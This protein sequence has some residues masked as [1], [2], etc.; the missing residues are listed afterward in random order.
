MRRFTRRNDVLWRVDFPHMRRFFQIIAAAFASIAEIT[1]AGPQPVATFTI[2]EQFGVSHPLQIIDFDFPGPADPRR[3]YMIGPEGA[4][5]AFQPLAG[6]KIAVQTDLPANTKRSWHLFAG[7]PP[8]AM[9]AEVRVTTGPQWIEIANGVT[10]VR[11][12]RVDNAHSSLAPIQGVRLLNGSWSATGPNYLSLPVNSPRPA[13]LEA[14]TAE[15][16]VLESGPLRARIQVEY[17]YDRPPLIYSTRVLVPGGPGYYRSI[18][19]LD[20]GSPSIRIEDETDMDL[21][22]TLNFYKEVQPNQGRYR[23][24]HAT[25]V[26]FGQEPDGSLYHAHENGPTPDAQRDF[27]YQVPT[28]SSYV[29]GN[30]AGFSLLQRLGLWNPW[31]FDSGWY[32]MMYN[33]SAPPEAP[34]IGIFPGP[35]SRLIGSGNSGPGLMFLP[36]EPEANRVAAI[37]FQSNRRSPDAHVTPHIRVPWAIFVGSKEK[38][39]G[40]PGA[41]Q[42]I[43]KQTDLYAGI[44]LNKVYRY[45]LTYPDP[46][47]GVQPLYMRRD[48]FMKIVNRVRSEPAYYQYLY[49]AEPSARPM[50]DLWRD[51]KGEKADHQIARIL[52][53]ARSWLDSEVNGEGMHDR[54]YSY[55]HGGLQADM[56]APVANEL[57]TVEPISADVRER[58]K[59]ALALFC[60]LLWDDDLVPMTGRADVNLGTPNMPV[61]QAQY[62]NLYAI[63]LARNPAMKEHAAAVAGI[64]AKSLETEINSSGAQRASPH[65]A[66]ASMEPLLDTAQQL[67]LAGMANLFQSEPV[68]SKF[69]RFYMSMLTPPEVRFGTSRKLIS[70]GDG[71]TESSPIFGELG[72]YLAPVDPALSAEL[73]AA[74]K[75]SGS[76]HSGFHGTTVVKIDGDLP[77]SHLKLS[78][79]Q[80]PGWCSVLRSGFNTPNESALWF[81][82]GDFYSD[83]RHYD[84]GSVTFYA[85]GAP[86]AIDW[87]SIYT[88]ATSAPY[89]HSGV[90]PEEAIGNRWDADSPKLDASRVPWVRSVQEGFADFE[91]ATYSVASFDAANGS[92]W[93]RTVEMIHPD[94]RQPLILINDLVDGAYGATPRVATLNMMARDQVTTPAG[95]ITPPLRLYDLARKR[96]DLPSATPPVSLAAGLNRFHFQGQF[97]VDWDLYTLSSQPQQFLIGSWGHSSHPSTEAGEFQRVNG[98]PFHEQQYIFRVRGTGPLTTLIVPSRPGTAPPTITRNGDRIEYRSGANT[99]GIIGSDFQAYRTRSRVTLTA[100]GSASATAYGVSISG[101]PAEATLKYDHAFLTITGPKGRREFQLGGDWESKGPAVQVR[102]G[103]VAVDFDGGE[104]LNLILARKQAN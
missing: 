18:I 33:R 76:T 32:W 1:A 65:Y 64:V 58:L 47:E 74:W 10:G 25:S 2:S 56:A 45:Q 67:R 63:L 48:Q 24:H 26:A 86:I 103:V 54:L 27:G 13:R 87:G 83:H 28:W 96:L 82:N 91:G 62:R 98:Q 42:N 6:G 22:Y 102:P 69:A 99:E 41:T 30:Y 93:R 78:S 31:I 85:L 35:A 88:P 51:S 53:L 11:I 92:K 59:A 57:L 100:F 60:N 23:G 84:Q 12:A 77:A 75:A 52:N 7:S 9:P 5:V 43:A 46:P 70:I 34:L 15:T 19:T 4:Q 55:W 37:C 20:A 29:T 17:S 71:A 81:I 44:N 8:R 21:Q 38:D 3:N 36:G 79:A 61:Q 80:W 14:R 94:D 97:G 66:D 16:K 68:I 50:L 72:T 49:G 39:L 90:L 101:G 89:M 95:P 40:P 73:M 104:T